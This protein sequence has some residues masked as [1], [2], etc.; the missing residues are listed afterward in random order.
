MR[1][2][3]VRYDSWLLKIFTPRN[4]KAVTLYPYIFIRHR[5]S[6]EILNFK[7]KTLKHEMIHVE[8]IRRLGV[9]TF[10]FDYFYQYLNGLWSTLNHSAAYAQISYEVDAYTREEQPFTKEE[11][12]ELC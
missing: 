1:K 6:E 3:K 12:D 11:L 8:Q 5:R 4:V 9:L 10:Y 7:Q 2:I